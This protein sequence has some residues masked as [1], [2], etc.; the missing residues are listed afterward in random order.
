MSDSK[1]IDQEFYQHLPESCPPPDALDPSFKVYYLSKNYPVTKNDCRSLRERQPMKR[2]PTNSK[3]CQ[4]CGLSCFTDLKEA[5]LAKK[6]PNLK[7]MDVYEAKLFPNIGKI[8]STPAS[9]GN[10]HH[11]LWPY[12][13]AK[14]WKE[15]RPISDQ[16]L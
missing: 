4:A 9:S 7:G 14:P 11:T 1:E 6:F 13:Q 5:E 12:Q 8:K 15:F 16:S 2:F 10:S 3:E